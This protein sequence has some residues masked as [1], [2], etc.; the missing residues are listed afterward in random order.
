LP[1]QKKIITM[2]YLLL[3]I[4]VVVSLWA[5]GNGGSALSKQEVSD[6]LTQNPWRWDVQAIRD[7]MNKLTLG[8]G[9]FDV[10]MAA[11]KRMETGVFEFEKDGKLTLTINGEPRVGTWSLSGST[12]LMM[13]LPNIVNL[14]NEIVAIEPGKFML[15]VNKDQGML[16]PKIFVAMEPGSTIRPDTTGTVTPPKDTMN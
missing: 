12:T 9:E 3:S 10:I 13:E 6:I 16:F 7:S 4:I 5:C 8:Q 14:P 2:R 1:P 15:G 11:L